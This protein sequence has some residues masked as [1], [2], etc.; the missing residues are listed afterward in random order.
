MKGTKLSSYV[1]ALKYGAK[2]YPEDIAGPLT[3]GS[4]WYVDGDNGEDTNNSGN[5]IDKPKKTVSAAVAAASKDDVVFVHANHMVAAATDP[6]SYTENIVIPAGTDRLKIIGMS[7]GRTQG[8]L[9]QLKVGATTTQAILTVRAPGCYIGGLGINGSEATGGGILLDD[10]GSTK[11]AFGTTMENNHFKNCK[12]TTATNAATGG[13]VQWSSNGGAWQVLIG[14]N[15]FY[16][17]IG[18]VVLLGTGQSVP[19]DVVIERNVFGGGAA[20]DCPLY[21]AGGSGMNGVAIHKNYFGTFPTLG[22]GTNVTYIKAT[23]CIGALEDNFFACSGKTFGAAA[24]VIVPT[25]VLM[26]GNYQEGGLIAR[27]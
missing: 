15:R 13:A 23:G 19:Q 10:D 22:S 6:V 17:N 5:S 25:T 16:N 1:P 24:N 8:G 14:G 3:F 7:N 27:T 2:I 4:Y 11:S 26:A 20:N 12:G 9:P 21:L 18:D